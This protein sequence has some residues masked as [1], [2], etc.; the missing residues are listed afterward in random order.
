MH[1]LE[2]ASTRWPRIERG[3]KHCLVQPSSS[4]HERIALDAELRWFLQCDR[5]ARGFVL[6]SAF[7][8]GQNHD[9]IGRRSDLPKSKR[10]IVVRLGEVGVS[11]LP[12]PI[13]RPRGCPT[14]MDLSQRPKFGPFGLSRRRA[15]S[16]RADCPGECDRDQLHEPYELP[17]TAWPSKGSSTGLSSQ[18]WGGSNQPG[19]MTDP[20][21]VRSK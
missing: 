12:P 5:R 11:Y 7:T 3:D 13:W 8:T 9:P 14:P 16:A 19:A 10:G 20:Q 1:R 17:P 21:G 6:N 4:P 15:F 18:K 2:A